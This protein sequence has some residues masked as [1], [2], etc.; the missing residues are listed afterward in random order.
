MSSTRKFIIYQTAFKKEG[1][2]KLEDHSWNLEILEGENDRLYFPDIS[3]KQAMALL[4]GLKGVAGVT[5]SGGEVK[6]KTRQIELANPFKNSEFAWIESSDSGAQEVMITTQHWEADGVPGDQGT[7]LLGELNIKN[8]FDGENPELSAEEKWTVSRIVENVKNRVS[9]DADREKNLSGHSVIEADTDRW[10]A[11][12]NEVTGGDPEK[13]EFVMKKL[14]ELESLVLEEST[15]EER[16]NTIKIALALF[17][18][19]EWDSEEQ[20]LCA[21]LIN[22]VVDCDPGLLSKDLRED[23][24][25]GLANRFLLQDVLQKVKEYLAQ[26]QTPDYLPPMD[27]H[28]PPEISP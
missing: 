4:E 19:Q 11:A 1:S 28:Q 10:S 27:E 17:E 23:L 5:V 16:L 24:E 8:D 12:I 7:K 13:I 2:V 9:W 21:A 25:N 22:K 15:R 14:E 18:G 20:E 6:D 26:S 3:R